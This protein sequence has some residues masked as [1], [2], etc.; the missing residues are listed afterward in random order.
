MK[1]MITWKLHPQTRHAT[2]AKFATMSPAD[3]KALMGPNI[4]LIGRWHD[5][6]R[7]TGAAVYEAGDASAFAKYA[8]AW[9]DVMDLDVSIVLDDEETR[10]VGSGQ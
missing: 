10:A 2:L 6:Q 7:G 4:T 8:L 3:E 1:F 5:L 9:N